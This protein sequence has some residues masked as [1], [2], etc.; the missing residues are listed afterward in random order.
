[1]DAVR[2]DMQIVCVKE[3]DAEDNETWKRMI[4]GGDAWKSQVK[5]EEE[6]EITIITKRQRKGWSQ[7]LCFG[8]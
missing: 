3:R 7:A 2:E 6:E 5:P 4:G 1:M 8:G